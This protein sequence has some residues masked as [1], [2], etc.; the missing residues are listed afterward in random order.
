WP[1]GSLLERGRESLLRPFLFAWRRMPILE[2]VSH[3][4]LGNLGRR[5][6][7]VHDSI[8]GKSADRSKMTESD[9][10]D[11]SVRA[12]Q[13]C[14]PERGMIV[15]RKRKRST[16]VEGLCVSRQEVVP[17]ELSRRSYVEKDQNWI[18]TPLCSICE[19]AKAPTLW[20][21]STPH[22]PHDSHAAKSLRA[23]RE[24]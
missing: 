7:L 23:H 16:A 15:A 10:N 18:K 1:L 11:R 22:T 19:R 5:P 13:L 3:R 14:H 24:I 20:H 8:I 6:L 17:T 4:I 2:K 12:N 9:Q 21:T